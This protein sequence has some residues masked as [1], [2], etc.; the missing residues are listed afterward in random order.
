MSRLK[1]TI[2]TSGS[3]ISLIE[4]A[5]KWGPI[6]ATV[7]GTS[8][9]SAWGVAISDPFKKYAPVSWI[10]AA[11]SGAILG[12]TLVWIWSVAKRNLGY[13]ALLNKSAEDSDRINILENSF[14]RQMIKLGDFGL[15][16]AKPHKHKIFNDCFT[17]GPANIVCLGTLTLN[18]GEYINCDFVALKDGAKIYNAIFFENLTFTGGVVTGVT[19][20]LSRTAL[21]SLPSNANWIS[22]S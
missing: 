6:L 15:P 18:E 7:I 1:D 5:T 16:I 8:G 12:A 14:N 19:F 17:V 2:S 21:E 13:A 11:I 4:A 22:M 10:A 9:I 3:V 20:L